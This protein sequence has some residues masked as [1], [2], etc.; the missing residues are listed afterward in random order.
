MHDAVDA[1]VEAEQGHRF[2]D[3][4][5]EHGARLC[6][7]VL[8]YTGDLEIARDAVAEA[9]A[10]GI[11]RGEQ[12]GSPLAWITRTAYRIAAGE[13]KRRRRTDYPIVERPYEMPE[14]ALELVSALASLSPNQRRAVILHFY[15]GYSKAET[16]EIIGSTPSA[17]GVHLNRARKRLRDLLGDEDA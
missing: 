9:F 11:R 4:Y 15:D 7:S 1:V 8:L 10:Q 16:A 17:V 14:P 2:E 12:V 6:R 5:R 3:V 13:M